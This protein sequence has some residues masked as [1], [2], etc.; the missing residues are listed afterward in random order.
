MVG[1]RPDE[2]AFLGV[3]FRRG[4]RNSSPA[5]PF[6]DLVDGQR[7]GWSQVSSFAT[8]C[9]PSR[10]IPFVAAALG[11]AYAEIDE[12]WRASRR[13]G[14]NVPLEATLIGALGEAVE[15]YA[16]SR[17]EADALTYATMRVAMAM[18]MITIIIT[19]IMI[20]TTVITITAISIAA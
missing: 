6:P 14:R 12:Y 17:Y 9:R 13:P 5:I 4:R 18:R 20:T 19:T 10:A 16:A 7:P 3:S 11:S 15:R 2:C 1:G 8:A